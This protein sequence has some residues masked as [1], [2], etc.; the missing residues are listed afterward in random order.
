[1][2]GLMPKAP[3]IRNGRSRRPGVTTPR[4]DISPTGEKFELHV[5][6]V[7]AAALTEAIQKRGACLVAFSGGST[8]RSIY[9][10]LGDLLLTHSVDLSRVHF[11]FT[12]ERIVGPDDPKSN[13]GMINHALIS[14][15][16]IP[17]LHVHRI[18]G[19]L[20]AEVAAIK[21]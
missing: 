17:P 7:I 15:I 21:Y 2:N 5:A 1:M 20:E 19:E 3:F 16:P 10:R 13:Y 12:D 6:G 9:R 18:M 4:I 14:R 8:P 11:I